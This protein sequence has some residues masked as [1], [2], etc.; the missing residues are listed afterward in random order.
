MLLTISH[1]PVSCLRTLL[2]QGEHTIVKTSIALT[3]ALAEINANE[4]FMSN[5][6]SSR[7]ESD[8]EERT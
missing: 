6:P 7:E 3:V 2:E 5:K 8:G 1:I 4:L